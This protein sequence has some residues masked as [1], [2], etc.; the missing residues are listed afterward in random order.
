ME[1]N[2][3]PYFCMAVALN[4][5]ATEKLRFIYNRDP[6]LFSYAASRSPYYSHP[7]MTSGRAQHTHYARMMLGVL[8][9]AEMEFILQIIRAGWPELIRAMDEGKKS[10]DTLCFAAVFPKRGQLDDTISLMLLTPV[11]IVAAQIKEIDLKTNGEIYKEFGRWVVLREM[12][13]GIDG[14]KDFFNGLK[15]L[16]LATLHD[17]MA[18]NSGENIPELAAFSRID[19]HLDYE[20]EIY[21]QGVELNREEMNVISSVATN[22]S[23]AYLAALYSLILKSARYDQRWVERTYE[24]DLTKELRKEQREKEDLKRKAESL[25]EDKKR[26]SEELETVR[27]KL[28]TAEHQLQSVQSDLQEISALRTALYE[29]EEENIGIEEK[30]RTLP[31]RIISLGGPDNWRKVMS[32]KLS[33]VR[34]ISPDVTLPEDVIRSADELW[35]YS[36]YI[37]HS[38]FYKAVDIAK[39]AGTVIRYWPGS[40]IEKCVN[41]VYKLNK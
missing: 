6:D 3:F 14:G 23:N 32:E 39:N 28:T 20:T 5:R 37:G 15:E 9:E 34:F 17:L 27:R 16:Q 33:S 30:K 26:I 25:E 7:F 19:V 35:I 11:V 1:I 4:P 10:F 41:E 24:T 2:I 18:E 31:E 13:K 22:A 21:T 12:K 40:N 36:T 8:L 29:V 38:A